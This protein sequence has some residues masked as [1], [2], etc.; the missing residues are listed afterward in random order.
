[1][2][3]KFELESWAEK[4]AWT[5]LVAQTVKCLP[6]MRETWV[7]SL[8]RE[9]LLEKEM[10]THC[11]IFAWKIPWTVEPGRLQSMGLQRVK[12]DWA[13][14]LS[15][16]VWVDLIQSAKGALNRIKGWIRK[17][18]FSLPEGFWAE[19]LV[20]I[21]LLGFP[22]WCSGKKSVSLCRRHGFDPWVGKTPWSRKW[23][24]TLV[25]LPGELHEQGSLVSYTSW[26][27]RELDMTEQAHTHW[28]SASGLRFVL[29]LYHQLS[30]M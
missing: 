22:R 7:Q 28:S 2:R 21:G 5:S 16:S 3:L 19:S 12:Y 4:F 14:S 13:T 18:S 17:N 20:F 26:G 23:K 25:F 30:W 29:E 15:L 9:D 1:M 24:P 11:S 8:G 6:T 27:H 10:A